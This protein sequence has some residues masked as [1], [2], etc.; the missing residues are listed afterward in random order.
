VIKNG[1]RMRFGANYFQNMRIFKRIPAFC[2]RSSM[3]E[4][5]EPNFFLQIVSLTVIESSSGEKNGKK[6]KKNEIWSKLFSK[7]EDFKKNS[8]FSR[9]FVNV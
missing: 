2:V 4:N 5:I 7:Y 8:C 6:W 3:F 9:S 1:N